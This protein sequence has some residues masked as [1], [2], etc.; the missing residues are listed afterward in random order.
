MFEEK[1]V[2][3]ALGLKAP[4][5]ESADAGDKGTEVVTGADTELQEHA[6]GEPGGGN[7]PE[8]N[9]REDPPAASDADADGGKKPMSKEE[10]ARNASMRRKAEMEEAVQS[11]LQKQAQQHS[12][13][14]QAFF[15]AANLR[16]PVSGKPISSMEEFT[17]MQQDQK[18]RQIQKKLHDGTASAEELQLLMSAGKQSTPAAASS[19]RN[20][21]TE[22]QIQSELSEIRKLDPAMQSLEDILKSETS[23]T[24]K[25]EVRRGASFLNAFKI[26]NFDRLQAKGRED[27]ARQ[28]QQAALNGQRSKEHLQVSQQR[29]EGSVPVPADELALYRKLMPKV[30]DAEILAHYNKTIK[31]L[32]R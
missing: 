15:A 24:F 7:I 19:A 32:K 20:D 3:A 16:D 28:A 10:R 17:A 14:M 22:E 29:G 18:L 4:E 21:V 6:D 31:D 5:A 8:E 25:A 27:S 23:E 12:E 9:N 1:D 11:A 30:S 13:Q 26:A 2:Y